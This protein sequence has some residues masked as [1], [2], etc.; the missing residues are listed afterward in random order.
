[1][2]VSILMDGRILVGG[3][4]SVSGLGFDFAM[5]RYH[6][7]G[8]LDSTFDND[9]IVTTDIDGFNDYGDAMELQSDGKIVMAGYSYN[10]INTSLATIR[11]KSNGSLDNTFGV[12]GKVKTQVG[13]IYLDGQSL[14]IQ[15][16]NKIIVSATTV[17]PGNI[18]DV[19]M[20]RYNTNGTHDSTFGV[21]GI[22]TTDICY[23]DHSYSINLQADG[24]ILVGGSSTDTV[25]SIAGRSFGLL[26][27]NTNGTLDTTFDG[28]GKVIS[29]ISNQADQ[30]LG[31]AVQSNGKIILVGHSA[32]G[33]SNFK[34]ALACYQTNGNLDSSFGTNGVTFTNI[35]SE[36]EYGESVAIQKDGKIVIT[37]FIK[38]GG[39]FEIFVARYF[40]DIPFPL[41]IAEDLKR[42]SETLFPNPFTRTTTI[43]MEPPVKNATLTL[44]DLFGN[45]VNTRQHLSGSSLTFDRGNIQA[46]LYMLYLLEGNKIIMKKKVLI[47]D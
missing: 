16:D 35:A 33:V 29:K 23:T 31:M 18:Y 25:T 2:A 17:L 38:N 6:P 22:V 44:Y 30:A 3:R 26:R 24:K 42:E 43:I 39:T 41:S 28:D 19:L 5:A 4:S 12:N 36:H 1:M 9:G 10:G 20:T 45:K 47:T 27:Y 13:N 34:I 21:N 11:Y 15:N 40:G 7:N 37:G 14:C 32:D 46:G 8:M